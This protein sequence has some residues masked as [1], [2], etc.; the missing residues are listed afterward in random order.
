VACPIPRKHALTRGRLDLNPRPTNQLRT[1]VVDLTPVLPGGENGGAKVF[2]LELLRRLA[3]LAPQTQFVLLTQAAAHEELA[4]LDSANVRRLMIL[5]PSRPPAL[6]SLGIRIFSRILAHLPGRLRRVTGRLGY[7]LLTLSKRSRSRSLMR[8]LNV[9]LLFCPFTAPTYFEPNVPTVCVI[10]DLQHKTYPEFFAAED[11]AHR[12]LTFAEAARRSTTL[13]AISDYSRDAAIAE[14]KLDPARIKTV[15][16][17]ISQHSLRNATR[18]NTILGR[19]Q[20]VA[21]KYLI[22]PANFW[23]HKNHEM[24]LT[25]FGIAR[26]SGLADD[27]RLVCTGAPGE[28]QQWLKLAARTLG[29]ENQILFP[30]YLANAELLALVSN[31]AGVV[32][33]S[34]YEGFGLPVVEA[35]AT[36]VPVACGNVTSL[37]EVAGDAAILFNPRVPEDIAQAIISLAQEEELTKRLV[38][39]GNRRAAEFSDSRLMAQQYWDIF[40]QATRMGVQ[41]NILSGANADGWLGNNSKLQIAA[42]EQSR[43]LHLE[44]ALPNWAPIAKVKMLVQQDSQTKGEVTALRGHGGAVSIPLP[45]GG[46]YFDINLA[47]CF[48]PSLAGLGE[49]QR[50]LSAML[51][52]CTITSSDGQSIVLFPEMS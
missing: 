39:A 29:L 50:E 38:E 48:V 41:S 2:V 30:G 25:A 27:I 13:V 37:P 49:D 45:S 22:Y 14:G 3:E 33:P 4:A 34:L 47:P 36:G 12:D 26:R 51:T 15:R 1:I 7:S 24:L 16:L 18:D 11:V 46:G 52:K 20:L 17:H 43:T 19:L 8:D 32:F 9:D 31:S 21:G 42:S 35:M 28:R 40:E 10:Y 44:I 6:R 5:D 23:K